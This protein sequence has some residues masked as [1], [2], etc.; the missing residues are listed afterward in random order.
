MSFHCSIYVYSMMTV[1]G[2]GMLEYS[3]FLPSLN[4]NAVSPTVKKYTFVDLVQIRLKQP[5][6]VACRVRG[7]YRVF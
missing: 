7:A 5:S 6:V 1:P 3:D 4:L 2:H